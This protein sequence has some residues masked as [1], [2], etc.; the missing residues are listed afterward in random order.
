MEKKKKKKTTHQMHPDTECF[1]FYT[2]IANSAIIK[3]PPPGQPHWQTSTKMADICKIFRHGPVGMAATDLLP[4]AMVET[5]H[6]KI[7]V[8]VPKET[9]ENGKNKW[10]ENFNR[11]YG[12]IIFLEWFWN[13]NHHNLLIVK[14]MNIK[15]LISCVD[16]PFL[17][18]LYITLY[19]LSITVYWN[20]SIAGVSS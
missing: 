15:T 10:E 16:F 20:T 18:F 4:V 7:E 3:I 13:M 1:L 8:C 6:K 11:K 17:Q 12:Y 5:W 9:K 2:C 19:K 14:S